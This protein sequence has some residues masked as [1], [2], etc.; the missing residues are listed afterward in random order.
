MFQAA[1]TR[2]LSCSLN[3]LAELAHEARAKLCLKLCVCFKAG[4]VPEQDGCRCGT[5]EALGEPLKGQKEWGRRRG[6]PCGIIAPE[7]QL[8]LPVPAA[9]CGHQEKEGRETWQGS[10]FAQFP[11]PQPEV[12]R[13]DES[14]AHAWDSWKCRS[15]I[16]PLLPMSCCPSVNTWDAGARCWGPSVC[17]EQGRGAEHCHRLGADDALA[18][19]RAQ[20]VGEAVPVFCTHQGMYLA[21]IPGAGL[22]F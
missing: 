10:K 6:F 18:N 22:G 5:S 16:N 4:S 19:S 9:R 20:G 7:A 3:L 8:M 17:W 1:L 15:G 2:L 14:P 12:V 11:Q 13:R 21:P